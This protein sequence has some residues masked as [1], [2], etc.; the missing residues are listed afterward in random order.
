MKIIAYY[1]P[2]WHVDVQR[3]RLMK[4]QGW[5]EWELVKKAKPLFKGHK[6]PKIPL[7]GHLDD[8]KR[9]TL[10]LQTNTAQ[11]YGIDAFAFTLFWRESSF[12][13]EEPIKQ[14]LKIKNSKLQFVFVWSCSRLFRIKLPVKLQDTSE[15][16]FK[17]PDPESSRQIYP[18]KK[19]FLELL[20]YCSK[21]YFNSRRYLKINGRPV[22]LIY[23]V[24]SFID[25]V[26]F[27]KGKEILE[28]GSRV[29]RHLG[30][31]SFYYIGLLDTIK[32]ARLAKQL[33][34]QA[35]TSY[36]SLP[37]L[38]GPKLQDYTSLIRRR[39]RRWPILERVAGIPY[40]PSVGTGW[41]ASPRGEKIKDIFK[42]DKLYYPW[43]PIVT[44]TSPQA[45]YKYLNI[46][47]KFN[48][49]KKKHYPQF[50]FIASWNEWSDGYYLEPDTDN[51]YAYLEA[52]AQFKKAR[53]YSFIKTGD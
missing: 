43:L 36:A 52:V 16:L 29:M 39:V 41:D 22:F 14:F 27:A 38:H 32:E 34:F 6:Q 1:Y 35:I 25:R 48:Q 20:K 18:T 12:Y 7:W 40:Y 51:K 28:Y 2:A 24:I 53:N 17:T 30:Y 44:K 21:E 45:F 9:E 23:D 10:R 42:L 15:V 37:Y 46:A 49:R 11:K 4:K 26:G 31:K 13:L 47:K 19:Y 50:I 5:T 33:G 8:S 3:N